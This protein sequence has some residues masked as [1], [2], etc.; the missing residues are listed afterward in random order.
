MKNKFLVKFIYQNCI[1]YIY[2]YILRRCHGPKYGLCPM[3]SASPLS[4][5]VF[6][7]AFIWACIVWFVLWS[8]CWIKLNLIHRPT[9][10]KIVWDVRVCASQHILFDYAILCMPNPFG[11][12]YIGKVLSRIVGLYFILFLILQ[13]IL[14]F[15]FFWVKVGLKIIF[16]GWRFM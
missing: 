2:I 12:I 4:C 9:P 13:S 5:S 8:L 6:P 11:L 7:S 1:I 14:C 3:F 15:F 16:W 10:K